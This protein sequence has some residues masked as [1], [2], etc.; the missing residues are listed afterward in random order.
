MGRRM[1]P[2]VTYWTGTWDPRQEAISKE[3]ELLRRELQKGRG[4]PE[5][6]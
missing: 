5:K 4:Q 2:R 3:V 6:E 1:P